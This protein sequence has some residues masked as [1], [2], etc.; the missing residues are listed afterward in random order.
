[1][2]IECLQLLK[3]NI[4]FLVSKP[5]DYESNSNQY[6]INFH[7]LKEYETG[8]STLIIIGDW[9]YHGFINCLITMIEH[10]E[11]N[12]VEYSKKFSDKDIGVSLWLRRKPNKISLKFKF[13]Y[14]SPI[15]Y[16]F[17]RKMLNDDEYTLSLSD[18]EFANLIFIVEQLINEEINFE[19]IMTSS[20]EDWA[21]PKELISDSID[22]F[23]VNDLKQNINEIIKQNS[24]FELVKPWVEFIDKNC[25]PGIEVVICPD[26]KGY[27]TR[28]V[29]KKKMYRLFL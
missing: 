25:Y 10:L 20:R 15:T 3:D 5:K 22:L 14:Q 24:P 6:L 16:L 7:G 9:E 29:N 12:T 21:C 17:K 27:F 23:T 13:N 8:I 28:T 19:E 11:H 26:C 2:I 4:E 18:I 1:M